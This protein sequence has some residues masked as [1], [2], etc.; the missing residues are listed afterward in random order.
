[1][2]DFRIIIRIS[3]V[4]YVDHFCIYETVYNN[5]SQQLIPMVQSLNYK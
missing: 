5:V 1:M 2:I 4:N 3:S